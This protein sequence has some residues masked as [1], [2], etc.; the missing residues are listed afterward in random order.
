MILPIRTSISPRR[1]PYA[2]YTLIAINIVIFLFTYH[3]HRNP[4]TGAD[5]ALRIWAQQ[6]MLVPNHPHVWQFVTYAF[7]HGGFAH[8]IGNMYFLYLFGN[9]VNDKLGNVGYVCFYLA[10]AVFSG[11][12]H[13][14]LHIN[15]VLGA[16]GAVA[17]VTGAYLVLF[18]KTG[19]T[20]VYWLFFIG[21][22]EV[23]ALYF[24]AFKLIVWDNWVE[25][26]FA[27][28]TAIAYDAHLAG[29]A[30]GIVM[31]M[32]L[33]AAKLLLHDHS[34]LWSMFRQ[35]N[36]RRRYR[37]TVTDKY[38]PFAGRAGRKTIKAR[39]VKKISAQVDREKEIMQMRT[40]IASFIGQ[41]NL[42]D[43]AS[44]YLQ[45]IEVDPAHVLPRQYQLDVANQLMSVENWPYS[46][47]A[48]EK[49]L[50]HY[51]TYEYTEQVQLMLGIL[52]ARYL[53][54]SDKAIENLAAAHEKLMDP[55]QLKMCEDELA[56]IKKQDL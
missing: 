48:Y 29:Y 36:R 46:A 20:I 49:F 40:E 16:S 39:E 54:K 42:T 21:T 33:F 5:E 3:P 53:K 50:T 24:I 2:N 37:D 30:F 14:L 44:K 10:G 17:A 25:P 35:W 19:V 26:Y 8:I 15:P 9:N 41:G 22:M 43:A 27:A 1:T 45:L 38:D 31:L 6:F 23:S 12:G 32:I 56:K 28:A 13:S 7:L 4:N 34:D 52:Y 47:Q 11:L 51:N 18:P 55:A